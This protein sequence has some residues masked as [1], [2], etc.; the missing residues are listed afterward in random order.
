VKRIEMPLLEGWLHE[1]EGSPRA[2]MTLFHGAGANSESALMKG[3]AEAF[4]GA[5]FLVFRGDLPFRQSGKKGPPRGDGSADREGIRKAVEEL[6]RLAPNAPVVLA[7]HSYGGRQS[8]ML[9]AEDSKVADALML[10]SYPLHPPDAPEKPRT[11]HFPQ[12]RTPALFVH[13]ARDPFGTIAEVEEALKLIPGPHRLQ[14]VEKAAH[15]LKPAIATSLPE[16]LS[17]IMKW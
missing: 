17:G 8:S 11:A 1:P 9:A 16:W 3:V 2:A 13:G 6:R 10:L 15:S 4:C 5:G 14:V 7:G 12:L